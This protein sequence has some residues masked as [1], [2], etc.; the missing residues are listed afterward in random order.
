M[1][2]LEQ[3]T[4]PPVDFS[5]DPLEIQLGSPKRADSY[6]NVK[7]A[8]SAEAILEVIKSGQHGIPKGN[9]LSRLSLPGHL[10]K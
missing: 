1:K 3:E 7:N 5:A 8:I 9:P 10:L 4:Q 6:L 2:G